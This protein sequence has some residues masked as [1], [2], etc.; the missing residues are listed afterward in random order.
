MVQWVLCEYYAL[1]HS[2]SAYG[3]IL[4]AVCYLPYLQVLH[5]LTRLLLLTRFPELYLLIA[6]SLRLLLNLC[7]LYDASGLMLCLGKS[8]LLM[9]VPTAPP[10]LMLRQPN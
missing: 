1:L 7:I 9:D 8:M 3:S 4:F 5:L 6:E 2:T 10:N